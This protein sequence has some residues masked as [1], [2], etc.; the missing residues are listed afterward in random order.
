MN[1]LLLFSHRCGR[2][3]YYE[4]WLRTA[5]AVVGGGGG[6]VAGD[7]STAGATTKSLLPLPGQLVQRTVGSLQECALL[8]KEVVIK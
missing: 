7:R 6:G 4:C 8:V 3:V 5:V 1:L 2:C